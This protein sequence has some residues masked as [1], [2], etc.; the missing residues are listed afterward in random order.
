MSHD[1]LKNQF[2]ERI[3]TTRGSVAG[4]PEKT[5]LLLRYWAGEFVEHD[6]RWVAIKHSVE[7]GVSNWPVVR[8]GLT[9]F[10]VDAPQRSGLVPTQLFKEFRSRCI[11]GEKSLVSII[12]DFVQNIS[13][14]GRLNQDEQ[15]DAAC[16]FWQAADELYAHLVELR[17]SSGLRPFD[18]YLQQMKILPEIV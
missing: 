14:L 3:G 6:D 18:E 4:N 7:T 2:L 15:F 8:D 13:A 16:K 5:R 12:S 10:F 17:P 11:D 1:L 9:E